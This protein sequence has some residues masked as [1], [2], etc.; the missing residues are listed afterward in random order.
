MKTLGAVALA[1][2]AL[3]AAGTASAQERFLFDN[4]AYTAGSP[5]GPVTFSESQFPIGTQLSGKSVASLNATALPATLKFEFTVYGSPSP[6]AKVVDYSILNAF[7]NNLADN[8][9]EGT[10]AGVLSIDFG[11]TVT[12]VAFDFALQTYD[13][14]P[15]DPGCTV[16]AFDA[17]GNVVGS[18]A[19][20][21]TVPYFYPEGQATFS[22][23]AGFRRIDVKFASSFPAEIPAL[24]GAGLAS[25]AVLLA[26]VGMLVLRRL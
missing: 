4:L 12:A 1:G 22:L 14:L 20:G 8:M 9:V 25:L 2:M 26:I 7:F 3:A 11:T 6:D 5:V 13:L 19:P 15:V 23:S 21:T 24:G 17:G 10:T 16:T 18:A